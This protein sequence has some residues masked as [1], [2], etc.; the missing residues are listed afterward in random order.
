MLAQSRNRSRP[1]R[2]TVRVHVG[3]DSSS[4][5]PSKYLT[6]GFVGAGIMFAF[7]AHLPAAI[8]LGGALSADAISGSR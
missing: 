5:G 3:A 7:G 8:L 6:I 2:S 4:K 1:N